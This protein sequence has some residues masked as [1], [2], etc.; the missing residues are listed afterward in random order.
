MGLNVKQLVDETFTVTVQEFAQLT[1][2]VTEMLKA[3]EGCIGNLTVT[4]K[5]VA[6]E[7]EGEA[8]IVGDLHGDLETLVQIL[9]NSKFIDKM[10][11]KEQILL[12]FLGDYGDRGVY[13]PEV[14]YIVLKLKTTYPANVVLLRGNHEGPR[15]ILPSPHDLPTHLQ[16][17]FGAE[18]SL[19]YEK[20]RALFDE[21][22]LGVLVKQKFIMLHGGVPSQAKTIEDVAFAHQKHPA[23]S[24]LEEIL[25]SDPEENL[26]GTH[27]SPRGA[28]RL[29]GMDVTEKFLHM[30]N[31]QMLIRGHEPAE[32]GYKINHDGRVLTLFSR[33][34]EPY[35]NNKA[36][37]LML[38]LSRDVADVY[39]L[40]DSLRLLE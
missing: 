3:K 8:I 14:F 29:F 20:L 40:V 21:L 12:V 38:D 6:T 11:R 9:T 15:D 34:G 27:Q 35:Y 7:P 31:V 22:H 19:A 18:W 16:R 33:K 32:A 39:Q 13:S 24:H 28:G 25:W 4:G 26:T 10:Q 37:Y 5:L 23:E 2:S 36:A 1:D 17:R 30:L